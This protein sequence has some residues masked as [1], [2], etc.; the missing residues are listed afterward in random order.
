M[1]KIRTKNRKRLIDTE[2]RLTA[3]R[4]KLWSW[5]KQV[6]GL[7]AHKKYLIDTGIGVM[8]TRGKGVG[9]R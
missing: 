3:V 6:K 4:G 1:D 5:V 2:N 9:G 7:N 8:T